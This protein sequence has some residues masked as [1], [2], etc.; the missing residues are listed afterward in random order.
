MTQERWQLTDSGPESYERFQVPS[1]FEPLARRFLAFIDL[2][3]GQR[4]L[5]V[6]CGTGIVAR[7]AA[8]PLGLGGSIVGIDLNEKMLEVARA[9]TP[10]SG[11]SVEWRLGDV[12][13]LPQPDA[14]FDVV[15]CQQGLQYFPDKTRAVREMRRVLRPGGSLGICVWRTIDHSPCHFAI[16]ASLRRHLSEQASQRFQAVFS[17]GDPG[18]IEHVLAAGGFPEAELHSEVIMRRLLPP[19]ESIPGLLASTPIGP[20]FAA[21]PQDAQQVIVDEVAEA[22]SAYRCGNGF[23][24]PQATFMVRA[25]KA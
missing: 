6:A 7:L 11:A 14:D 2:R 23:E 10:V 16:A 9:C 18:A 4:V 22:L 15:L 21:L 20:Y 13:S 12:E 8:P 3:P 17:F 24:V 19:Q 25:L 1:V 5:D